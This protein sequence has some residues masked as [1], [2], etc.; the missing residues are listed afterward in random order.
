MA[1]GYELDKLV[2]SDADFDQMGWHDVNVYAIAFGPRPSELSLDLDYIFEWVQP[3]AGEQFFR[4]WIAPCTLVFRD[5]HDVEFEGGPGLAE[6]LQ[7]FE[8]RR[9]KSAERRDGEAADGDAEWEWVL[10]GHNGCLSFRS[11]GFEQFVRKPPVLAQ[12]QSL[13]MAT[14]GGYSFDTV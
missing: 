10:D 12:S 3:A 2:W 11:A 14:R 6:P 1:D 13:D 9:S 4:F 5:V 8:L 7:L